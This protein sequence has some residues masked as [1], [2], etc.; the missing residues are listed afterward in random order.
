MWQSICNVFKRMKKCCTWNT[1]DEPGACKGSSGW[2]VVWPDYSVDATLCTAGLHHRPERIWRGRG[3]S[4]RCKDK[5]RL[6][7][8]A[9][10]ERDKITQN[11]KLLLCNL[12]AALILV[13]G[14][15]HSG[16]RALGQVTRSLLPPATAPLVKYHA[17]DITSPPCDPVGRQSMK[18]SG[19]IDGHRLCTKSPL[20]CTQCQRFNLS[21]V[22]RDLCVCSAF[23]HPC[24]HCAP[25]IKEEGNSGLGF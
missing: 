3:S 1:E 21:H 14:Q 25:T 9:R 12:H 15:W 5:P 16:R 11:N 20:R 18:P 22:I 7:K 13:V 4:S 17:G 6:M 23:H 10:A 8:R 19:W 2:F 24:S